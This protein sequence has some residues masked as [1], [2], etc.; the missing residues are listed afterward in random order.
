MWPS[1]LPRWAAFSSRTIDNSDVASTFDR[2]SSGNE[3]IQD[4]DSL[5]DED[6]NDETLDGILGSP[7]P[8]SCPPPFTDNGIDPSNID[9]K[10]YCQEHAFNR[11]DFDVVPRDGKPVLALKPSL[12]G[13]VY[14]SQLGSSSGYGHKPIRSVRA[15]RLLEPHFCERK[16]GYFEIRINENGGEQIIT[17]GVCSRY[18]PKL[19]TPAEY[20]ANF[21]IR[22]FPMRSKAVGWTSDAASCAL[23][24]GFHCDDGR[25]F[26]PSDPAWYVDM[27]RRD[28]IVSF[29][30][31]TS[32][33]SA[34]VWHPEVEHPHWLQADHSGL[35]CQF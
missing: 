34:Q 26:V 17:P 8:P 21:C 31:H 29:G 14:R 22:S 32:L 2:K 19:P 16:I 23:A 24:A 28:I 35:W 11:I 5:D 4:E 30:A 18:D 1:E 6:D 25:K 12:A 10:F 13:A 15:E 20:P 9:W 3:E 7:L 27:F 33:T